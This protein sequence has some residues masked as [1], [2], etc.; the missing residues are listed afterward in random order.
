[1]K[2]IL[3]LG[4]LILLVTF[5]TAQDPLPDKCPSISVRGPAGI[6][7]VGE[8]ASYTVDVS[9]AEQYSIEY[10]WSV[11][12]GRIKDG[13]GAN[14]VWVVQPDSSFVVT[15]DVKGLPEGCTTTVSE[16]LA[17]RLRAPDPIKFYALPPSKLFNK[18]AAANVAS[19][20]LENPNNQLYIL[21][22]DVGHKNLPAFQQKQKA[23]IALLLKFGITE[24]RITMAPVY[25]DVELFQFWR[26]PPGANN[27]TCEECNELE[28]NL[29]KPTP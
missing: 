26:V 25:S 20:M 1:M 2:A 28:R 4:L 27:P 10:V 11:S 13:Q 8:L 12:A 15:V 7:D 19:V 17:C 14:T 22:G 18:A 6:V 16:M 9:N 21:A 5:T 24:D 23:I 3:F 29:K